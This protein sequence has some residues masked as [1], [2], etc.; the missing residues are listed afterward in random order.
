[1]KD[2]DFSVDSYF[3]G[4]LLDNGANRKHRGYTVQM[5]L[6]GKIFGPFNRCFSSLQTRSGTE[7]DTKEEAQL[8]YPEL[9]LEDIEGIQ[10]SNILFTSPSS[11]VSALHTDRPHPENRLTHH[12]VTMPSS[13]G[14]LRRDVVEIRPRTAIRTCKVWP[15]FVRFRCGHYQPVPGRPEMHRNKF[16]DCHRQHK[17]ENPAEAELA[18]A[19]RVG[20]L[21][22]PG[23]MMN[24]VCTHRGC[25]HPT[26]ADSKDPSKKI[27]AFSQDLPPG[28]DQL[29]RLSNKF[30]VDDIGYCPVCVEREQKAA[31]YR[32]AHHWG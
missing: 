1:M 5:R 2:M 15:P 6:L 19:E 26:K 9:N 29:R 22:D 12:H 25:R 28:L 14:K 31:E 16:C 3:L 32:A 20:K 27:L 23:D 18:M 8:K 21:D 13:T 17:I 7:M 4:F 10:D 30:V 11:D 24:F